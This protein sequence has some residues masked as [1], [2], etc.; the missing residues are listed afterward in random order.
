MNDKRM[1]DKRIGI[2]D[3][4]AGNMASVQKALDYLDLPNRIIDCPDDLAGA[5]RV[6]LPGVGAFGAAMDNLRQKGFVEPIKQYIAEG[7]SFLGIC[8]GMQ[9]LLQTSEETENAK[10]TGIITGT[11]KRF[12]TGKVPHMGWNSINIKRSNGLFKGIPNNSF[13]YFIHSY[14]IE[15]GNQT[16]TA[17]KTDYYI[18]FT[19]AIE[20]DNLCGVQF[21]PEKSGPIGLKVLENWSKL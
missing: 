15:P 2:I 6:I 11:C 14:Y 7:K 9:L 18:P 19:A 20:K 12:T 5:E 13:F 16:L 1:N 17:A 10:G 21:H 4:G 8:L 3:Y